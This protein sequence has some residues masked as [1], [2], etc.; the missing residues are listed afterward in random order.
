MAFGE[1][2]A[3]EKTVGAVL[4]IGGGIGGMQAALDL[5]DSGFYV[6]MTE[7]K[8]AIGGVM[9]QLDKTFPTNDCS[10]CIMAPKLVECGR[11]LNIEVIT[12]SEVADVQG[13][14][15]DFTV[16][17]VKRGR[18]V[19]QEKC[20]GCGVCAMHCPVGAA[21]DEFNSGLG[22]RPSIYIEYPQAVPLAYIIDR[23]T[24]IGCGLCETL[25]LAQAVTY[26]DVTCMRELKV[27]AIIV[28]TG[29]D[30]YDPSERK[31]YGYGRFPNVVTSMEFE[32]ILSA[33]GPY[34]GRVL[35][36]SDGDIPRKIA[37]I[38]C[39]GSRDRA[40]GNGY[41]SS[42]CCMYATKEAVIAKEHA[43]GV[44][45][46]VFFMDM[47]SYGK[48]FEA[49]IERAKEEYG[50]RFRRT[51]VGEV[52]EEP[53]TGNLVLSY[54]TE[55]G[56]V[57]KEEFDIVVLSVGL[58]PPRDAGRLAESLG[59]TLDVHGFAET[60]TLDPLAT[61]R[62]GVFV[63]GAMQGP[64]DIPETVTQASGA[65]SAT[66]SIL[67]AGRGEL[68]RTKTYPKE[69]D[70]RGIGPRIGVFV[71]HCGINIGGVV[72]VPGVAE[73]AKTLPNVVYAE[74]NLYTCSQDT[75]RR[76][77]EKI[78]EHGLTRVV[79][80]SCTPRTHEPLFQET[81]REAGLNCYLFQMTNIRDQCSWVHMRDPARATEK[82]KDLVKAACA[83]ASLLE[84]LER[85]PIEVKQSALVIGGGLAG[86]IAALDIACQGFHV[87]LVET[88]PNLGGHLKKLHFT[89]SGDDIQAYLSDLSCRVMSHPHIDVHLLSEVEDITGYVGNFKS[90]ITDRSKTN[91]EVG[92]GVK[93]EVEH[94]VVV[95]A[96]G[97][98]EHVPSNGSFLYRRHPLVVTQAEFE[99]A[100]A[101]GT[102]PNGES[103]DG[104]IVMIQCV[105]SRDD[106]RGYCSRVCCSEAVKNA[107]RVKRADPER[108][109]FILYRDVRTYGTREVYFEEARDLGVVFIR[110]PD[111]E[112]PRVCSPASRSEGSVEV[113]HRT[114]QGP[115][116]GRNCRENQGENEWG[117]RSENG[118]P[119]EN[120]CSGPV[121]VEVT[122]TLLGERLSI[123]AGLVVL[124]T[125][126]APGERNK[127]IA[128]ML[129]VPLDEDGFFLEAH[130]KLRPVDFATEGVFVA[131]L[132]H[133]PKAMDETIA[134]AHAAAGRAC[135]VLA[136]GVIMAEGIKSEVA[137]A[138]CRGCGLCVEV[139]QYNAVELDDKDDVAVVNR[140]LCKGCG[141]C[142]AT[143][144]CGAITLKG[145]T[146][147]E[148]LA[149]VDALL[150]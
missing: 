61:T 24:C 111:S 78:E 88:S 86:M 130:M 121:M 81:C 118:D 31:E 18:Y 73:Y 21:R 46:T 83:K 116:Q 125:G 120:Y 8:S 92:Q 43:P 58:R 112:V 140:A 115:S 57:A 47:R 48:G 103:E 135:T 132:A 150:C 71:C 134:Q 55:E 34:E 39:V 52:T 13:T 11:H 84:P 70:V 4:V 143:C 91:G 77:Q 72:D 64:K 76:I 126:I 123:S 124:S 105:G 131:G 82:A 93:L 7:K 28:A 33:S 95:V 59:I 40:L 41:C 96:T 6:Y 1:R 122:D 17:L 129:K 16:R 37:F 85:V 148:I 25:C 106:E 49:Y 144:R 29:F 107:I 30:V 146:E 128:Q 142:A 50:V 141:L 20:T 63:C 97:G 44:E 113:S 94:G 10:M 98:R 23:E 32:R 67:E 109:V 74:E 127:A 35:R 147:E 87:D 2:S 149:E 5:A 15:G 51:R 136:K 69:K 90:S 102:F 99:E 65:A 53:D 139:C 119:D 14:P 3:T 137:K 68:T 75:Q 22:T 27:G 108:D 54:E 60:R 12:N 79:V 56:A 42:V 104:P 89:L 38:Q 9:A 26:D 110:Y 114:D 100:L 133:S 117:S 36:P 80:A 66:G 45:A 101:S 19:D 138:R 145:F 62:P